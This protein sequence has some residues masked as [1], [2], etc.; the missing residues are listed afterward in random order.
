MG[1]RDNDGCGC[2][3]VLGIFLFPFMVLKELLRISK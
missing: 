3:L 1:R 2:L